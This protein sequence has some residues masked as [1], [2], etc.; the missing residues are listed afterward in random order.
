MRQCTPQTQSDGP[1]ERNKASKS[2]SMTELVLPYTWLLGCE[3]RPVAQIDRE[4]SLCPSGAS[5]MLVITCHPLVTPCQHSPPKHAIAQANAPTDTHASARLQLWALCVCP[6]SS[7]RLCDVTLID[8][9]AV[10]LRAVPLERKHTHTRLRLV[11]ALGAV[12]S[13]SRFA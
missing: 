6:C 12:V 5:Y 3:L 10:R 7:A 11:G 13:V 8:G 2:L 1:H 9:A 4:L